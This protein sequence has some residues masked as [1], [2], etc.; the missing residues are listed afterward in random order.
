MKPEIVNIHST[1]GY[2]HS[3]D[4]ARRALPFTF[5]GLLLGLFLMIPLDESPADRA[6]T[7]PGAAIL[8]VS[9]FMLGAAVYRRTQPSVPSI[10]L[11]P[12]GVLF[13]D[14]SEKVIP[15]NEIREVGIAKVSD[16][17]DFRS[18]TVT[19]LVV[20]QRFYKLLTGGK[21]HLSTVARDGDPSEIYMSYYHSLPFDAFHDA[22]RRRW[23]AFSRHPEGGRANEAFAETT[24]PTPPDEVTSAPS[25]VQSLARGGAIQRVSSF[26]GLRAFAALAGGSSP[27]QILVIAASL[28]GI[29]ALLTNQLGVWS[30]AAQER[31]RAKA[32]E[33]RAIEE[34]YEAS[35]K[36]TDDEQ[37][38]TQDMWDRTYKCM[39]KYW[40]LHERNE[41]RGDPECMRKEK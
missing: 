4:L 36:A 9:L 40:D 29:A 25:P 41:Y 37:R 14:I 6:T 16:P 26:A 32:A 28:L 13:R 22:L 31:G 27:G 38:R 21:W 2:S 17:R 39:D 12:L 34:R 23:L 5:V 3:H 19:K 11:S 7:L 35:R 1:V 33:W 30:T 8:V 20:S 18:T 15:W 10:V 24:A